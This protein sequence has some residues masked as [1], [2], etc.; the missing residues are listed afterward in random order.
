MGAYVC[1]V[2]MCV[3]GLARDW[4]RVNLGRICQNERVAQRMSQPH[5]LLLKN[6]LQGLYWILCAVLGY[7]ETEF[8]SILFKHIVF[9][10]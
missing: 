4:R 6:L 9:A 3:C 2:C 10:N 1:M 8:R 7:H 5:M